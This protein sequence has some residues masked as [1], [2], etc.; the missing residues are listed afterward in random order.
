MTN[1]LGKEVGRGRVLSGTTTECITPCG[2]LFATIN[3]NKAGEIRETFLIM[4][5]SGNC[6]QSHLAFEAIL[7]SLY[8]SSGGKIEKIIKKAKKLGC[9]Q[10]TADKLSCITNIALALEEVE[11]EIKGKR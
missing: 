5:K 10:G 7:M 2:K 8:L 11:N 4:G 3:K 1:E 6:I 9:D